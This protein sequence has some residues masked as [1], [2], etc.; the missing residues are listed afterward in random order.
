MPGKASLPRLKPAPR[1]LLLIFCYRKT[2]LFYQIALTPLFSHLRHP[3]INP[4]FAA[5]LSYGDIDQPKATSVST[6][7]PLN[8]LKSLLNL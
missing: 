2:P 3:T 5:D 8:P 6:E 7:F 4:T 1:P